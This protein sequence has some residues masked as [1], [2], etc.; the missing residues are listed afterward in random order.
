MVSAPE[1][2]AALRLVAGDAADTIDWTVR[3]TSGSFEQRRFALL[4][5]VPGVIG[6][7][8]EGSSALASDYY[9]D[10]RSEAGAAGRFRAVPVVLDRTVKIRRGVA[11]ASEPLS[12]NDDDAAVARLIQITSKELA[13]PYR[14]TILSNQKRDGAAVGWKRVTS[15]GACKFCR[16]LADRGAVYRDSTAIFASHGS[17]MCTAAPVFRGGAVGPEATV[18]QY[19]GSRR[20]Q[21][22]A[23]KA[24]LKAYLDAYPD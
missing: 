12:T 3:R 22:P 10:A 2:Q 13:Y 24:R 1:S 21:T 16:F 18:M 4:E 20:R 14:D 9:E 6:Y 15:S 17:C 5:A 7:Y 19:I 8:S 11:W 23:Q